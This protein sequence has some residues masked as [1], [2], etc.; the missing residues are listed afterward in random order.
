MKM[1]PLKLAGGLLVAL[2]LALPVAANTL[3]VQQF[4]PDRDGRSHRYV[5]T[6][7]QQAVN[8]LDDVIQNSGEGSLFR[9]SRNSLFSLNDV[10]LP[11]NDG[12]VKTANNLTAPDAPTEPVPE[13]GTLLLIAPAALGVLQKIRR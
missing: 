5:E 9:P 10:E 8:D 2:L 1:G 7:S 3:P 13:P 12:N 11:S 6:D 4:T